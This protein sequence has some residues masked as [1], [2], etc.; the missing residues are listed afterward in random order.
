MGLTTARLLR[1]RV[2]LFCVMIAIGLSG[3]VTTG[4]APRADGTPQPRFANVGQAHES[5]AGAKEWSRY[6]ASMALRLYPGREALPDDHVLAPQEA[7]RQFRAA[8]GAP[9]AMTWFGHSTFLLRIGGRSI[10]TDPQLVSGVGPRPFRV[11]RL[12][13]VLPDPALIDSLDAIVI[14]HADFD[15]FDVPTLRTLAA[16][17][18]RAVLHVPEGTVRLARATGFANIVEMPWYTSAMVGD[19]RI[20]AVPAVHGVRRPPFAFDSMHWAGY[21]FE[22]AGRQ[23]YFSGDTGAG[24]IFAD[25][26][27]R[28]GRIDYAIMPAGGWAPRDFEGPWHVDPQEA[29]AAAG[30][31]GARLAIGMHWGTFALSAE[32]GRMQ[33]EKFLAAGTRATPSTVFRIGETRVMR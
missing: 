9:L 27:R 22:G 26:R 13:P 19:V 1:A 7:E 28:L 33:R 3:C 11:P 29:I 25:I 12:V 18:P 16:R 24:T 14:S 31:L 32:S 23:V 8:Q 15:H 17:F 10:L 20:T 2:V 6:L 5:T 30:T 21:V 4:P